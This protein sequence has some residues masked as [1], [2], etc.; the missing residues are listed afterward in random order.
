MSKLSM[1]FASVPAHTSLLVCDFLVKNNTLT[2]PELPYVPECTLL[3]SCIQ[4]H[5]RT[6][7]CLYENVKNVIA[8]RAQTHTKE[9]HI[10]TASKTEKSADRSVLSVEALL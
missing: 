9:S 5:Q 7:T 2:I 6:E 1:A 8:G 10:K 4:N 3:T